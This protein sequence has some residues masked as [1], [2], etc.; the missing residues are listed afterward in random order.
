MSKQTPSPVIGIV[1]CQKEVNSY[2]VQSVNEFYIHAVSAFGGLPLLLTAGTSEQEIAQLLSLVDGVL[3]PGS[4]SNVAPGQYNASHYESMLDLGRDQ[5]SFTV[6]RQCADNQTP[7]LGICRGFQE[8]NVALGGSLH[9][10]VHELEG[11]LDHREPETADFDEKYAYAHYVE[12]RKGGFFEQWLPGTETFEV[13]SL[14]RQGVNELAPSLTA[15]VSAPDG[16]IEAFSLE[17]HPYFVGVQW[18][19]E[20]KAT[21]IPFSVTLFERFISSARK[22][23]EA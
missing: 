11:Y 6:I 12:I 1:S 23:K 16:L 8:M 9:P 2:K 14:H 20:W 17:G 22:Q 15:E 13:N 7:I 18:H 19:P 4:H 10:K 5:L 21:E 3:L